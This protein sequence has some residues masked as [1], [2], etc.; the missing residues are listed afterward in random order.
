M[1]KSEI[2]VTFKEIEAYVK[3]KIEL[4]SGLE[5]TSLDFKVNN[6]REVTKV[7]ANTKTRN[8]NFVF[9]DDESKKEK[10]MI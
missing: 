1:I 8:I 10:V 9:G 4:E 7:I 5:V 6:R 2:T 3:A